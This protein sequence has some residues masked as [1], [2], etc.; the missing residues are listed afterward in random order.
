MEQHSEQQE[1]ET[2]ILT[3]KPRKPRTTT[4]LLT[5]YV[6][7]S[8]HENNDNDNATSGSHATTHTYEVGVDEAGRGPL[9]GRVY[10]AAVILPS[11]KDGLS[12][13]FDFSLL[14]DSKKF[15]SDKKI[16]EASDYIKEHAVAW[17][18]SYEEADVIDTL[19]IRRATLQCMRKAIKNAI[20]SHVEEMEQ[21]G[22]SV[23]T[24]T[25]YLLLV[26]GND[27]IPL[28]HYNQERDET[29]TYTHV[30][31][32]GGDN[33]Y[34]CIAAASILAKVARDEYIEK[35]CDQHP[36]LDEMYSLRGNK[37]YG[38]KKH[39]DGIREHGITQWHRRSYGICKEFA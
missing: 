13:G 20:E 9:F 6:A 16:R 27:F 26:D 32:E 8:N 7:T 22:R 25:D 19:N 4:T 5:S 23:P 35:L 24:Y 15:S 3:K 17:A 30:C 18:I 12:S 39:L 37:G 38:A 29:E 33:T 1:P 28:I 21:K 2:V 14:K 34:A 10:T 11:T 36:V 31:V